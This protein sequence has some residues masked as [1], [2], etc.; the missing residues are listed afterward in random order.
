M[1]FSVSPHTAQVKRSRSAQRSKELQH[2]NGMHPTRNSAALIIIGSSGR[3]MPGVRCLRARL[4]LQLGWTELRVSL[5]RA[6][7]NQP[8]GL[9]RHGGLKRRY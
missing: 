1:A 3:V 4:R 2:N 9:M 5:E 8:I 6:A 7:A